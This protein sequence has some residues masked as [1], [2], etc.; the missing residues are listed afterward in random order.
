MKNED[1]WFDPEEL[2]EMARPTLDRVMEAIQAGESER[3]L[4]LCQA[5]KHEW[6][7]LHDLMVESVLGL[8]D[9]VKRRLGADH[10]EAAWRASME[11]GWRRDTAKIVQRDRRAIVEALAATWRAHSTSGVGPHPG[12]FTIEEDDEK[13]T[14]VLHP[15]GS[16]QRLVRRGLYEGDDGYA[17]TDQ[18]HDWSFGRADFPLYCTHCT[19]MNE[20]LPIEW[21]GVPLYPLDPPEDYERDPC[22]WYWYKDPA[23]IPDRFA[24]RYGLADGDEDG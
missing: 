16:G 12:A 6:R 10:V 19:L 13:F 24:A 7:F 9:F 11:R 18:A 1:R 22:R 8:V 2:S 21:Y 15:C 14:F 5:M 23:T 4:E 20:R 3:A 17:T